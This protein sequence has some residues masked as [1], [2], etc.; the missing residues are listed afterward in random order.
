MVIATSAVAPGRPAL[1]RHP[2]GDDQAQQHR[3][4][5]RDADQVAGAEQRQE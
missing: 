2:G 4:A 1:G 3:Y 5:H